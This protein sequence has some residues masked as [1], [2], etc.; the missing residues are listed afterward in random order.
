M[1]PELPEEAIE[2]AEAAGRAFDALGGV[3]VARRAEADPDLRAREV[4]PVLEQLG[5]GDLD[6]RGSGLALAAAAALCE[7]AGRVVLPYPL[8]AVL[9][10]DG[11]GRPTAAIPARSARVDHATV[12]PSWRVGRLPTG[13]GTGTGTGGVGTPDAGALGSRLGPFVGDLTLDVG[14]GAPPLRDLLVQQALVA[15]TVLGS[16]GRAVE[17]ATEHVLGRIQFGRPLAEFQAVQFHLADAAV[18]VAGLRELAGFT[19]WRLERGGDD[20]I[21]DVLALRSHLLEVA[22]SV[23]RSTQQLHGAAGVCDEYDVSVIVR[24]V[25]PALRLPAG[26]D[27]TVDLLVGS[28][29]A[30]GF[31]GLFPHG[32]DLRDGGPDRSATW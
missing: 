21:V 32:A 7:A 23:L 30:F 17:L 12:V 22:R 14:G 27:A 13:T 11:E 19:L 1:T 26:V 4:L 9:V 3:E 8:A 10:D 15:W 18:A 5:V 29:E 25:Q 6:P 31:V 24:S 2:L 16:L 28:V 20:A